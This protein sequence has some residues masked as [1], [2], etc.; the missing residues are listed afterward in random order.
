[1]VLGGVS[2]PR[3]WRGLWCLGLGMVTQRPKEIVGIQEVRLHMGRMERAGSWSCQ[4]GGVLA[5]S[6]HAAVHGAP[7]LWDTVR[8]G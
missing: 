2:R 1:M 5:G 7:E 3:E 4:S 6:V 8:N